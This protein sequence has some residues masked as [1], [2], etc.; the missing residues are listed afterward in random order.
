MRQSALRILLTILWDA[1]KYC[2]TTSNKY[3]LKTIL[4]AVLLWERSHSSVHM[5][6]VVLPWW[7]EKL[8]SLRFR[9]AVV[10]QRLL[11]I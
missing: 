8:L 6:K 2:S 10:T 4:A 9:A 1:D 3:F 5:G 7:V 11:D